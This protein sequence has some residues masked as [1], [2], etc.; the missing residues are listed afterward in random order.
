MLPIQGIIIIFV[1]TTLRKIKISVAKELYYQSSLF[2]RRSITHDDDRLKAIVLMAP[3][4]VMFRSE[5]ALE[6]VDAPMLLCSAEKDTQLIEPHHSDVIAKN[7]IYKEKSSYR[8]IKT[9][10]NIHLSLPFQNR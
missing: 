6:K 8:T 4:G 9:R 5:K 2:L 1:T 3:V 7:Y 10:D